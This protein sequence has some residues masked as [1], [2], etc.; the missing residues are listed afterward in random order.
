MATEA[1]ASVHLPLVVE[2]E[3]ESEIKAMNDTTRR[4]ITVPRS[5]SN[6]NEEELCMHTLEEISPEMIFN[7]GKATFLFLR[8]YFKKFLSD[9]GVQICV[10]HRPRTIYTVANTFY[11]EPDDSVTAKDPAKNILSGSIYSSNT[12]DDNDSSLV[13]FVKKTTHNVAMRLKNVED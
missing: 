7:R 8:L 3:L 9:R 4:F 13:M 5:T 1:Q 6:K 10:H 2:H 11:V 12:A